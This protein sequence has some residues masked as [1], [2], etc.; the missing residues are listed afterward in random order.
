MKWF[1]DALTEID[2]QSWDL[3]RIAGASVLVGFHANAIY[4]TFVLRTP[5]S[6]QDYGIGAGLI[7][8]AIGAAIFAGAKAE[9]PVTP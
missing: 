3:K 9:A 2:G 1:K 8:G 5:P 6:L 4:S 7:V